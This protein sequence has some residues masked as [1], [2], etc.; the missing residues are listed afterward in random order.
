MRHAASSDA[1]ALPVVAMWGHHGDG[2]GSPVST[3]T[4]HPMCFKFT[5]F[6]S[7]ELPPE[8]LEDQKFQTPGI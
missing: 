5:D 4:L 2:L 7:F 8:I 3:Y 1:L 6:N